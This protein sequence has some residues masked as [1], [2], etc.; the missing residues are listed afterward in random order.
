M[1]L[2]ISYATALGWVVC[3]LMLAVLARVAFD[4]IVP[5]TLKDASAQKNAAVGRVV[6]GLYLGL[7]IILVAA[8]HSS[9]SLLAALRDGAV[10]VVVLLLMFKVYDFVD[11][12][13]FNQ[14]LVAGNNMLAMELEGLFILLAAVIV[15]AMNY[16]G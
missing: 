12:R 4:L 1:E 7:A 16:L 8:I 2:L 13:D 6:R 11:R 5:F 9:H 3:F 14:E 15:G 10:G